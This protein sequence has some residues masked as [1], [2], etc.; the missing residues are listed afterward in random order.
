MHKST[1]TTV[2]P[3][4]SDPYRVLLDV[5]VPQ[6]PPEAYC[7]LGLKPIE[8]D[9]D[10]IDSA[11]TK[12]RS[13]LHTRRH[14]VDTRQWQQVYVQLEQAVATL[15]DPKR[16]EEYDRQLVE[17]G[18]VKAPV[19]DTAPVNES[20]PEAH[21]EVAPA[22]IGTMHI[23]SSEPIQCR[24]CGTLA[25][26]NRKFCGNC[27]NPLW[28]PCPKCGT[29]EPASEKF[30]GDC[31]VNRS[32]ALD[33]LLAE[34]ISNLEEA[35]RMRKRG[36]F[37][38]A[39]ALLG[40]TS[41][42][43]H[44][45]VIPY[46][47][48]A[49]A[50]LSEIEM[51]RQ[52][53]NEE[54]LEVLAVAEKAF[55]DK[56]YESARC[57]L[58]SI[59]PALRNDQMNE[60]LAEVRTVSEE[61]T[62]LDM[63]IR[64]GL[65]RK[66]YDGMLEQ[67]ARLLE[68]QPSR[69]DMR[70]LHR[71]LEKRSQKHRKKEIAGL[72]HEAKKKIAECDYA[73]AVQLLDQVAGTNQSEEVQ[74][75]Y[76]R[77]REL[78]WLKDDLRRTPVTDPALLGIAK[79]LVKLQP[80]DSGAADLLKELTR[81]MSATIED[82]RAAYHGWA[83]PSESQ[84]LGLPVQLLGWAQG[85]ESSQASPA[86]KQTI[87]NHPGRFLTACGLALQGLDR[88]SVVTN[89]VPRE[90][91][92]FSRLAGRMRKTHAA[93]AWGIDL[94]SSA[95]KA[96]Q[97]APGE[98]PDEDVRVLDCAIIPHEKNLLRSG[99]DGQRAAVIQQTL[100]AF[101]QQHDLSGSKICV[102]FSGSKVLSRFIQMPPLP[103]KKLAEAIQYEARHQIPFDLS[104]LVWDSHVIR[105]RLGDSEQDYS[106]SVVLIAAKTAQLRETIEPF[107]DLGL[108]VD[109]LQSDCMALHN[110]LVY[111][112][113]HEQRAAEQEHEDT[114]PGIAAI[115][116]GSNNINLII[117]GPEMVW[118]RSIDQGSDQY[119]SALVKQFKL[120][121]EAAEQLKRSPTS[122]RSLYQWDEALQAVMKDQLREIRVSMGAYE[123]DHKQKP[124][125][126][127]FGLGGGFHLH[128]LLRFFNS[129]EAA[130]L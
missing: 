35:N 22:S 18:I 29:L 81:R 66:K 97:L 63:A 23:D 88:A 14:V 1:T 36:D 72:F 46:A 50:L 125:G 6:L 27:G 86:V 8:V 70:K 54:A 71:Q 111:E 69:N 103:E 59:P 105:R 12:K 7:L 92:V 20:A 53:R 119:T 112:F 62:S 26:P 10:I 3:R 2:P 110:F 114:L 73:E 84:K 45:L 77:A 87:A 127:I 43:K 108:S 44:S 15:I 124:I 25:K 39:T 76:E 52:R 57:A 82:P 4:V 31:G 74:Q 9:P 129:V 78:F 91:G 21:V 64:K 55:A 48:E 106:R 94:G 75:L 79:R 130:P 42:Q 17:K 80:N 93:A 115:D 40:N 126:Q 128:G 24:S 37:D 68:L 30:C 116:I 100:K 65:D 113:F 51:E 99:I 33:T 122:S 11:A 16:K 60:L 117:S 47:E 104:S 58:D 13:A 98:S 19:E 41:E 96:V 32:D 28:E 49:K 89:L 83:K 38:S 34:S 123:S 120:T 85:I 107:Q 5:K 101:T 56:D 121:H 67:V 118:F 102:G 90:E 109:I 95:L 61:A